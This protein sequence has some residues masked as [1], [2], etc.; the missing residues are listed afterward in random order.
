[1]NGNPNTKKLLPESGFPGIAS[2]LVST[3]REMSATYSNVTSHPCHVAGTQPQ[4]QIFLLNQWCS[5]L[6]RK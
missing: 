3:R 6:Y 2:S 5:G 4:P 1:M